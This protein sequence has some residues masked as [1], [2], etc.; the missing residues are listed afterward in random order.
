MLSDTPVTHAHYVALEAVKDKTGDAP[1]PNYDEWQ[2]ALQEQL[3]TTMYA[4][5]HGAA[6]PASGIERVCQFCEVR[7]LCRKGAW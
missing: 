3:V 1:A 6:L 5:A 7:G 4:I 2:R